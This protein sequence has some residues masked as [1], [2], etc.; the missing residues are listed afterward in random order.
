MTVSLYTRWSGA[1]Q[2][3]RLHERGVGDNRQTIQQPGVTG[4]SDTFIGAHWAYLVRQHHFFEV[5]TSP[6]SAGRASVEKLALLAA[7]RDHALNG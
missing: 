3:L 4:F 2:E 6:G 1:M 7:A 5:W